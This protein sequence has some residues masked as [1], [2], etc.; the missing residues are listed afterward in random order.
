MLTGC[1]SHAWQPDRLKELRINAIGKN[2]SILTGQEI[3]ATLTQEQIAINSFYR[4]TTA[5]DNDWCKYTPS[6]RKIKCQKL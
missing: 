2:G 5:L 1:P 4:M 3:T 6:Q